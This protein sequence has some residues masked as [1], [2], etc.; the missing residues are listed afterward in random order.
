[1]MMLALGAAV[2]WAGCRSGGAGGQAPRYPPRRPGCELAIFHALP[3]G[4]GS[5]DDLGAVEV[6]CHIN[7]GQAQC[8]QRL[9]TEACRLGG[10]MIYNMPKRPQRPR[11]EVMVYRARVGHWRLPPP[12]QEVPDL[13][14]PAS[15]EESSGPVVPLTGPA[16][17]Q[18]TEGEGP[19]LD[20]GTGLTSRNDAS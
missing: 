17:P 8:L 12:K 14:P 19:G 4:G 3:L 13:P 18:G 6:G 15:P 20:G 5:W 1:M 10:D 9:R 7:T 2:A 11:D 16:A